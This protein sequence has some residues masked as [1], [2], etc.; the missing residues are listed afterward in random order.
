MHRPFP[1]RNLVLL[2]SILLFKNF[3][4]LKYTVLYA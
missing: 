3:G 4:M 1:Y 2:L